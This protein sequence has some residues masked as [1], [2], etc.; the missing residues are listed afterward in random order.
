ME[1]NSPLT[2]AKHPSKGVMATVLNATSV[3]ILVA[4][5]YLLGFGVSQMTHMLWND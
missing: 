3:S 2:E 4:V 1:S 5:G